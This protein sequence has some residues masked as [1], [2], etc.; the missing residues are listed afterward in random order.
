MVIAMKTCLVFGGSKFVGRAVATRLVQAGNQVYILNRGNNSTP[1]DC[2]QLLADRNNHREVM[3]VLE[4]LKF[5]VVFDISAYNPAQTKIAIDCLAG[6]IGHF[7]HISSATVYRHTEEYPLNEESETGSNS[8]WG[9]YGT[10]KY[11]C[12]LELRRSF[13]EKLFPITIFRPFYLYGPGNSHDRE[14]Y[15]FRWLLQNKPIIVPRKGQTIVQ[16]GHIDDLVNAVMQ[17]MLQEK[18]F[19]QIYN[20]SGERSITFQGWL[21]ACAKAVE[22]EPHMVF[23]EP[24]VRYE[25][26]DSKRECGIYI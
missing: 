2:I 10:G 7:I 6:R 3:S 22:V 12:E 20:I 14:T 15:V 18:S 16:F 11:L 25:Q 5:D 9:T 17:S 1:P 13:Q 21:E 4:G 24:G 23:V 8:I 19:G 26:R